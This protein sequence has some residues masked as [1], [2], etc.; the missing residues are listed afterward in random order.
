MRQVD[1]RLTLVA[2]AALLLVSCV[3]GLRLDRVAGLMVDDAWYVLL[4][5]ALARGEGYRLVSSAATAIL[6]VVPPGFPAM[7]SLVFRVRP[8]F[9]ENV[10]LLKS[11][12]IAAMLGVGLFSYHF[13]NSRRMPRHLGMAIA[14]A[15]MLTPGF[16]FLAT[17][18]VMAEC[19]FT[20]GQ[21]TTVIVVERCVSSGAPQHARRWIL[22]AG[23]LAA[24]TMLVRATG[25]ALL[26]SAVWYLFTRLGWRRAALFGATATACLSPWL[27]YARAH[28]P[29]TAQRL[30]HGGSIAYAYGDSMRMKQAADPE[31]G[32]AMPRDL[33]ARVSANVVNILGRDMAG[34]VAPA[35]LR[36]ASESG[37]E[38][39]ALGG[40][41]GLTAGSMGNAPATM[42]ISFFFGAIMFAG[43]VRIV[44]A[45][46]TLAEL[47][48][49]I[50]LAMIVL[51]PF[52]TFRYVLPLT[53]FLLVYLAEG[54]RTLMVWA[55]RGRSGPGHDPWR[56]ARIS[57]L[58][59]IGLDVVDHVEYIRLARRTVGVPAVDWLNDAEEIDAVMDWMKR[60][61]PEDGAV[62]TTN[63]GLVYLTTGRKT[64]AIDDYEKNW[65]RWKA[66]GVRYAVALRSAD[67]PDP[68]F[69]YTLLYQSTRRKLW[70][71]AI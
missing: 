46:L 55:A 48:T 16:V 22:L 11:V 26:L 12:S 36:G 9:P 35:L 15:T 28:E 56:M 63:P 25:A 71:I 59:I 30:A 44:R 60:A 23:G 4:G 70:V 58:C 10:L 3:Y 57:M 52:F 62:A 7:L 13:V 66:G 53:P 42:I 39:I 21:L 64:V 61:L 37:E 54:L 47:L 14:V 18:T 1:T 32:H 68:A 20:L 50:S 27:F 5:R 67:L 19:V 65:R 38:M 8:E 29:T 51:V 40:L 41:L 17:S 49:P 43:Y 6:P 34:L 33:I 2:V 24:A 69:G 45:R 31:S